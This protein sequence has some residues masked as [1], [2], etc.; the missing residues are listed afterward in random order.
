MIAASLF[1]H[2]S[3]QTLNLLQCQDNMALT[4]RYFEIDDNQIS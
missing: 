3:L 1:Q 4:K 2:E